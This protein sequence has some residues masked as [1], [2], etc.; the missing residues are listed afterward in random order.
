M[1]RDAGAASGLSFGWERSAARMTTS[2]SKDT[3]S[4][5]ER[6][7]KQHSFGGVGKRISPLIDFG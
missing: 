7:G 2:L 3:R 4:G 6:L 1:A 5:A